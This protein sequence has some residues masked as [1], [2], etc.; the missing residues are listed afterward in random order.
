MSIVYLRG[1]LKD[2]GPGNL[3]MSHTQQ[4]IRW[5]GGG[6]IMEKKIYCIFGFLGSDRIFWGRSRTL[7]EL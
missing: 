3:M 5:G 2:R 6:E 1:H 7:L 4:P